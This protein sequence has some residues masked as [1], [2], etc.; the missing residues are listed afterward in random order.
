MNALAPIGAVEATYREPPRNIELEQGL[1]G[2]LLLNNLPVFNEISAIVKVE[3]FSEL[4]HQRIYEIASSLIMAGQPATPITLKT[5][6]GS[7]EVA[8]GLNLAAYLARL[9]AEYSM[10][11]AAKG[12]AVAVH[13][14]AIRRQIVA[15]AEEIAAQAYDLPVAVKP[16]QMAGEAIAALHSIV[17]REGSLSTRCEAHVSAAQTVDHARAVLAGE[18]ARDRITTGFYDLD[19]ATEGYQPGTLW[20]VGARPGVGKTVFATT[21]ANKAARKGHGVLLFSLEVAKQQITSRILADLAYSSRRPISF[22]SILGGALD[23]EDL[24]TLEEVQKRLVQMPLVLDV[25]SRLSPAEI[26]VRVKAERER[27]AA[28]GVAL[29]VVFIDYLKQI[30]ASDRYRGNRVYEIGEITYSLKQL[31]KDEGVCIVLLAQLNRALEHRDDKRPSLSDLR[32]SGD[33]ETDAD[34]VAFLHREAYFTQRSPEYRSGR[35]DALIKFGEQQHEAEVIIGKNR[36]GPEKTV[37]LWCD[38]ACSTM[39]DYARQ[40]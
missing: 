38:V 28:R 2:S 12:Y 39:A 14:L 22:K 24:W 1:L 4:L 16:S 20:V 13:D 10:P 5:F 34:V 6:L 3:D 23:A 33:L 37:R 31:A 36:A 17:A 8:P 32:E 15:A 11:L 26:R 21:S 30:Q 9:C 25:A 35:D 19:E 18:I 27:M 7:Q 40:F 29:G